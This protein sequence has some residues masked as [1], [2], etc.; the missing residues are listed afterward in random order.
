MSL[1]FT[2]IANFCLFVILVP[3]ASCAIEREIGCV[4]RRNIFGLW[5]VRDSAKR[6]VCHSSNI[7]RNDQLFRLFT[8]CTILYIIAK[9]N[10]FVIQL[11]VDE[12]FTNE[13]TPKW[14]LSSTT[15][16]KFLKKVSLLRDWVNF[17]S[18]DSNSMEGLSPK[19]N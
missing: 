9:E 1:N 7:V 15:R 2:L 4:T 14:T 8:Q 19:F 16:N 13:I 6:F 5:W 12:F 11:T 17:L 3:S 10:T 18:N